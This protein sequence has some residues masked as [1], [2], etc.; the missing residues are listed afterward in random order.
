MNQGQIEL[1]KTQMTEQKESILKRIHD[2]KD[3]T[4]S[5]VSELFQQY[6]DYIEQLLLQVKHLK[7]RGGLFQWK[8][9]DK[10]E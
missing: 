6:S 1:L 8:G 9:N 5:T 3:E 10:I 7:C 4:L 2:R